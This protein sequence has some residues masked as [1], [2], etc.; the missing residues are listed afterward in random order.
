M[1]YEPRGKG[2][3]KNIGWNY[4]IDFVYSDDFFKSKY[5]GAHKG[6]KF[7]V[8][9]DFLFV[10]QVV[11][12]ATQE[13]MLL[14]SNTNEK[15]Y[16]LTPI[17][18]NTKR[19]KEHSYTFLDTTEGSVLLHIN[20][21]GE[22]SK[23]GH[24]YI[25]GA[26]GVRYSLSLKY[27]IRTS[28]G[29]IDFEKVNSLEGLYISNVIDPEYMKNAE[30]EMEEVSIENSSMNNP[31][32]S[33]N[34]HLDF[35]TTKISYNKGASWH[36]LLAPQRDST[37]KKYECEGQCYL[38][39][40]GP[41]SNYPPFYS[42]DSAVGVIVANGNIGH[43]LS[44]DSSETN[45][46]LTRD[47]GITWIEIKK[48]SHIYEI[49][50]HGGLIILA[51]NMNPTN[52][53]YYSWDE[54]LSFQDLKISDEK[55]L[56]TNVIIEPTSTSQH[57]IVYGL[58]A[59]KGVKKGVVIG[60]DFTGLHEPQCKNPDSPD[61]PQSDYEKWTPNDGRAGHE[62]LRG[63][64]T[65]YVRR[66]QE[67]QCFN[68][69]EFERKTIVENCPCTEEDFE[70]DIGYARL[71]NDMIC[72][73]INPTKEDINKPP[74][75]CKGYYTITKGYRRIPGDSCVDGVKYDAILI[76]CPNSG[77]LASLTSI[78]IGILVMIVVLLIYYTFNCDYLKNI[79]EL[80]SSSKNIKEYMNIVYIINIREIPKMKYKKIDYLI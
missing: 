57:F 55:L 30:Q 54:G 29:Q 4:K 78:S 6:N 40:H 28:N 7:M 75:N 27:N 41:S 52:T 23:Y 46:F 22:S 69:L 43:Y 53:L 47:G 71:G 17:E 13:V 45:T 49:G 61:T 76:P 39:L 10:A 35:I 59:K 16:N 33:K 34:P 24:V 60:L 73:K 2:D 44:H 42:V 58:T 74:E 37:G 1:T 18:T 63:R 26:D 21:F 51:D 38:N 20:H 67:S 25:S 62:C 5:I 65:I 70:C 19:F 9:K 77:L 11:D 32:S 12:Q 31:K 50:D 15:K 72:S 64:K 3:Q 79:S 56:I 48:G 68:G 14:V 36:R 8:T 66:K 80:F